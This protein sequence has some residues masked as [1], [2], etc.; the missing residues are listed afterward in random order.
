[1]R[2][3]N[4]RFARFQEKRPAHSTL[5]VFAGTVYRQGYNKNTIGH[6]FKKLVDPEDYDKKEKRRIVAWLVE[7]SKREEATKQG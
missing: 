6:W 3:I 1:M 7:V 4:K 2:S 5:V